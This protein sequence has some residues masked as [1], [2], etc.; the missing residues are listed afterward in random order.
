LLS[1]PGNLY[2]IKFDIKTYYT[3]AAHPT[4][5]SQTATFDLQTGQTLTLPELFIP[6]VDYLD[7]IS[8]Y[9]IAELGARAIGF[10]G[11]ELGATAT[12]QN[13]HNWNITVDGLMITFDEY[14]G[15]PYAAGPQ[16]VVIPYKELA[17]VLRPDGPLAQYAK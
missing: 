3:G 11:F 17:Q 15:A 16:I 1:P 7:A 9:C 13:Y 12:L 14:Q 5:T 4:D 6:N 10:Q 2:S 8:K